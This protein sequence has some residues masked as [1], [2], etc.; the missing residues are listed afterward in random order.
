VP[1][2][3]NLLADTVDRQISQG[4]IT[5]MDTSGY[6]NSLQSFSGV[7][8]TLD[9][10]GSPG[11]DRVLNALDSLPQGALSRPERQSVASLTDALASD[12]KFTNQEAEEVLALISAFKGGN[13]LSNG[14][15]PFGRGELGRY[16]G[17]VLF[18]SIVGNLAS[19]LGGRA[20]DALFSGAAG[21]LLD[22]VRDGFAKD[23]V[24][25]A[26][27]NADFSRLNAEEKSTLLTMLGVATADCKLSCP[28]AKSL[29]SQLDRFLGSPCYESNCRPPQ[30]DQMEVKS[31]CNGQATIDLGDG[32]TLKLNENSSEMVLCNSKTGTQTRVWGDPHFD[33][34]GKRVG[35][36]KQTVSL[37]LENGVKITVNTVPWKG[38]GDTTLASQLTITKGDQVIRVSGLDQNQT[39]DLKISESAHGGYAADFA[40]SDG[41]RLY[42]NPAGGGWMVRDGCFGAHALTQADFDRSDKGSLTNS[43]QYNQD[44]LQFAGNLLGFANSLGAFA[45]ALDS[46]A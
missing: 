32:Y 3:T 38:N 27:K 26:F 25:F 37:C 35:D 15:G 10:I 4:E 30:C 45:R 44:L 24:D 14:S 41:L 8:G 5:K 34:N 39:G 40:V 2:N 33:V 28:E 20:S 21:R 22:G 11:A 13:P 46:V 9:R 23:A 6:F 36:F 18:A 7:R 19:L 43:G 1:D 16:T 12:G 31:S 42:E 29:L 17:N